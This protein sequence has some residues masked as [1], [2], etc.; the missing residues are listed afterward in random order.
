[1]VGMGP[2]WTKSQIQRSMDINALPSVDDP[3]LDDT[4]CSPAPSDSAPDMT[5]SSPKD[6]ASGIIPSNPLGHQG[7]IKTGGNCIFER[8]LWCDGLNLSYNFGKIFSIFK[9]YGPVERIK[10]KLVE[11]NHISAFIMLVSQFIC[12]RSFK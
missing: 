2:T 11:K 10:A 3:G 1:M 5:S 6:N 12:Q 4:T 9:A 7:G 8:V